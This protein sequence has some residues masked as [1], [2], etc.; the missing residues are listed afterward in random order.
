MKIELIVFDLDGTLYDPRKPAL[1]ALE[2]VR[3]NLYEQEG[4]DCPLITLPMVEEQ[5][6]QPP[7]AYVSALFPSVKKE[8]YPRIMKIIS[9]EESRFVR[10]GKG[11]LLPDV[12]ETLE[13]LSKNGISLALISNASKEYFYSVVEKEGLEKFF[14]YI[15][16]AGDRNTEDKS[17]L[18]EE[19]VRRSQVLPENV[20]MVGDRLSDYLAAMKV[21]T[22][23]AAVKSVFGKP[24]EII[25]ATLK[26]NYIKELI[27]LL[28]LS[29]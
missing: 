12:L 5:T 4:I 10:L 23:F 27:H 24:D 9:D 11:K 28:G 18:L 8:F 7:M 13:V 15:I 16:C 20:L 19:V 1:L 21:K 2:E 25:S 14:R 26:I 22:Y 6:G 29:S 3:R 17:I